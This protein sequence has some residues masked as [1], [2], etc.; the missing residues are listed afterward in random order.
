LEAASACSTRG[1]A[2]SDYTSS[3]L[4]SANTVLSSDQYDA[5]GRRWQG[6]GTDAFGY[7]GQYGYYTDSETGLLLL[8]HRYYHAWHARFLTRDHTVSKKNG[9]TD[10]GSNRVRAARHLA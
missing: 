3:R 1:A 10:T 9:S 5:Y 6:P 4:N 8:T 2:V 7:K